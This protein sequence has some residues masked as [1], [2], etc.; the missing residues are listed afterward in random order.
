MKLKIYDGTPSADDTVVLRLI[1]IGPNEIMLAA[2]DATGNCLLD[3]DSEAHAGGLL[4][5]ADGMITRS[6]CVMPSL[7]FRLDVDGRV[8]PNPELEAIV[9]RRAKN[10]GGKRASF[11]AVEP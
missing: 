2:V 7:G 11:R 1:E 3:P 10:F 8:S 5:I 6:L 4:S 9:T